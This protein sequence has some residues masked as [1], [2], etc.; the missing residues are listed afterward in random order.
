MEAKLANG[1][2]EDESTAR[3]WFGAMGGRSDHIEAVRMAGEGDRSVTWQIRW[4]AVAVASEIRLCT[5]S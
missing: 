3:G 4:E 1:L 2:L 5:G